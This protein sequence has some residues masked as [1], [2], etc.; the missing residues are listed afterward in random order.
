MVKKSEGHFVLAV[1]GVPCT[2]KTTLC[3]RLGPALGADVMDL[4]RLVEDERLYCGIDPERDTRIVDVNKLRMRVSKSI[5]DNTILDGLLS[6]RLGATH[7]LVLRCDPML[8]AKRMRR[9]GYSRGKISENVEAEYSGVIL[10]ESLDVCGNVYEA[11]GTRGVDVDRVR[12]WVKRGGMH[13][14]EKDWTGRFK[15]YLE[16]VA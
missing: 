9:R 6:H 3:R 16:S 8:L 11:D 10:A 14:L 13:I 1:T 4:N 7:V 15:A 12:R 5:G 2:G